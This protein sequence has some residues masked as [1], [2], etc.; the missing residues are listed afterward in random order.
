MNIVFAAS[1]M[2]PF[3]K[4]GGLADVCGSLP[5]ALARQ[6]QTVKVCVPKYK[7][8]DNVVVGLT[9]IIESLPITV[10]EE[11]FTATVYS[12]DYADGVEVLFIGNDELFKRDSLYGTPNGDYPDNDKRFIFFQKAVLEV[13]KQIEFQP[14]VIHCHDWQTALIPAYVKTIYADDPFYA[15]VKTFF[16]IHNMAYQ[17]SFTADTFPLTGLP[18][19]YFAI[20]AFEY[21]GKVNFLKGGLAFADVLTTVS[22]R[23]AREIQLEE[24]GCGFGG[25]IA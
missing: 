2:S 7:L 17:G 6:G 21:F 11:E 3:S 20:D 5:P 4:T 9:K 23:Y 8:S 14:E 12:Y 10:G 18:E 15:S 16:T 19:A 25:H 24:F 1:E 13:L 22:D